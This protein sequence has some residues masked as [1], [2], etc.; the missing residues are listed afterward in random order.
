M[1]A[2]SA[3]SVPAAIS[4]PSATT[5]FGDVL[6]YWRSL[7]AGNISAL[8]R[9]A[10]FDPKQLDSKFAK[11]SL[12]RRT[13]R[14]D[15]LAGLVSRDV[16]D[17]WRRPV[18]GINA[19]DLACPEMRENI[20]LFY[21][22]VLDQPCGALVSERCLDHSQSPQSVQS[23]YLPM[24]DRD[25]Q[26][27][28]VVGI[29]VAGTPGFRSSLKDQL[30]LSHCQMTSMTFVDLGHGVPDIAFTPPPPGRSAALT[31]RRTWWDRFLPPSERRQSTGKDS[32]PPQQPA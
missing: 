3:T 32:I 12:M 31:T 28:Y 7:Q 20:A 8:P 24:S 25:G 26:P 29:T 27:C 19:F 15:V 16:A 2:L 14:Y 9:R 30:V 13:G 23:L 4:S 21:E 11:L 10:S 17:M 22:A 1:D 5:A 18:G 6:D